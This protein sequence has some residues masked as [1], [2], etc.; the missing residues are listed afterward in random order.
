MDRRVGDGVVVASADAVC[1]LVSLL[2]VMAWAC[3]ESPPDAP[4]VCSAEEQ[5]WGWVRERPAVDLLIVVDRSP[6][7]ADQADA[8]RANLRAFANV[9]ASV[10]GGLQDLHVAVVDG[11]IEKLTTTRSRYTIPRL[12]AHGYM[13]LR[14]AIRAEA[15]R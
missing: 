15:E 13:H 12:V 8:L 5:Q 3:T 2:V 11:A 1:V 7:M 6:S 14:P 4:N 10:E 9:L